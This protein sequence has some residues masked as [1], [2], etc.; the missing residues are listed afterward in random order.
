[1]INGSLICVIRI[2]YYPEQRWEE[3]EKTWGEKE[4]KSKRK[5]EE[6]VKVE[7]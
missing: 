4:S 5:D 1:M 3:E 6:N 2:I 7:W